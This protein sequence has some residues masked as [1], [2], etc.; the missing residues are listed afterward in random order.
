MLEVGAA[1]DVAE[2]GIGGFVGSAWMNIDDTGS[3]GAGRASS[4]VIHSDS[5]DDG[6]PEARKVA[7]CDVPV[8]GG[9]PVPIDEGA[10][11]ARVEAE[12]A[13]CPGIL[14]P[15][16]EDLIVTQKCNVGSGSGCA[17]CTTLTVIS[18]PVA[19]VAK[20]HEV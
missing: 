14:V 9:G 8:T 10:L 17:R 13:A 18:E 6:S 7:A 12:P 3:K 16:L 5:V 11:D 4:T 19:T 1:D 20:E 15:L 2:L